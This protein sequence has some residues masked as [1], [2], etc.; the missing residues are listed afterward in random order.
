MQVDVETMGRCKTEYAVERELELRA[1]RLPQKR[2]AAKRG[3][4]ASD[5]VHNCAEL[6]FVIDGEI[7]GKQRDPLQRDAVL[8]GL[9][10][11]REH[12]PGDQRLRTDGVE[13]RAQYPGAVDERAT[14]RKIHA[15]LHVLGAPVG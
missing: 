15:G 3:T 13:M 2:D 12:R 1:G 11:L 5:R 6:R 8:P 4:M 7:G 10:H 14:E 9:A